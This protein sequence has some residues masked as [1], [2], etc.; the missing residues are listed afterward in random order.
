MS[1]TVKLTGLD[2]KP[3][4]DQNYIQDYLAAKKI[5]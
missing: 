5:V 2:K 4:T 1:E 3:V